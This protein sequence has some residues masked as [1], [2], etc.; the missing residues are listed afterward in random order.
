[1]INRKVYEPPAYF[2]NDNF[3]FRDTYE[4]INEEM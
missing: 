4:Y 2:M 1:V 3:A